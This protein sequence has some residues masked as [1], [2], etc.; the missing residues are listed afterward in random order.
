MR[1][2]HL[3]LIA[4]LAAAGCSTQPALPTRRGQPTA[5]AVIGVGAL[6][7][8]IADL[9]NKIATGSGVSS[10]QGAATDGSNTIKGFS[11]DNEFNILSYGAK[12]DASADSS[13]AEQAAVNAACASQQSISGAVTQTPTVVAPA[14]EY[15][16]NKPVIVTC[17]GG[18]IL[19]RGAGMSATAFVQKT[20]AL[21]QSHG[22]LF[23]DTISTEVSSIGPT[24]ATSLATGAG[25]ALNF[26]GSY[27]MLDLSDSLK[28][29]GAA[30][31]NGKTQL[32]I[33]AFA[34][35]AA[36]QGNGAV[37]ACSNGS[38]D[39]QN[40]SGLQY[41]NLGAFGSQG[42]AWC[43]W[44]DSAL[45]LHCAMNIG[46]TLKTAVSANGAFTA[47]TVHEP[48][49][50]YDGA[51]L[52]AFLDGTVVATTAATGNINQRGDEAM[53]IAGNY[54]FNLAGAQALWVGQ[55][56]S[57]EISS[58]ARHTGNYTMDTA[59]FSGDSNSIVLL[60]GDNTVNFPGSSTPVAF[61]LDRYNGQDFSGFGTSTQLGAWL[62]VRN[63][64]FSAGSGNQFSDF[65]ATGTIGLLGYLATNERVERVSLTGSYAGLFQEHSTFNNRVSGLA[66]AS[67]TFSPYIDAD[68]SGVTDANGL[69]INT[70][71]LMCMA[72]QGSGGSWKH[73]YTAPQANTQWSVIVDNCGG[74]VNA[75]EFSEASLDVE[76]GGNST[77]VL[78][79][80][81]GNYHFSGGGITSAGS[82]S[83][84]T[85]SSTNSFENIAIHIQDMPIGF[86]LPGSGGPSTLFNFEGSYPSNGG[87]HAELQDVNYVYN[88][89][90][91]FGL[92][93]SFGYSNNSSF[94]LDLLGQPPMPLANFGSCSGSLE[95]QPETETNSTAA[96]SNGTTATSAGT[97]H[98]AIRC[99]GTNWIQ[100][101]L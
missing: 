89:N 88:S 9:Y 97:T 64:A 35:L 60:D 33:R 65:S 76:N 27:W 30:P 79:V 100:T 101:G 98:C 68:G 16:N 90:N 54:G 93:S 7:K 51:N 84:F 82:G 72:I 22:P 71:G 80:C 63:I 70:C 37:I 23:F 29:L 36:S 20:N 43:A 3:A 18:A 75:F 53:T 44:V 99:N 49:C 5:S 34:K 28:D 15:F 11:I 17:A 77:G 57:I 66:L 73:I 32:D 21:G 46:G 48:E 56:D 45:A 50:S 94:T 13:T 96:C 10:L 86:V 85:V 52:R 26:A 2:R 4:L 19:F 61:G 67:S 87:A 91:N 78:T 83:P 47:A 81:G 69:Q 12:R 58:V 8:S 38:A 55:L 31:F 1:R 24:T 25:A 59:K 39:H 95:G 62:M 42:G 14:G 40:A 6:Q 41:T 74:N 92:P